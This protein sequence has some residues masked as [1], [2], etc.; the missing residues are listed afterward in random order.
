M[1]VGVIV[2]GVKLED[3]Y[4]HYSGVEAPRSCLPLLRV[5]GSTWDWRVRRR[6][7]SE[8]EEAGEDGGE[9][10]STIF[11]SVTEV[12]IEEGE[13]MAVLRSRSVSSLIRCS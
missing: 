6:E 5:A 9:A 1:S 7:G 13:S 3:T 10:E 8:S 11:T 2:S 4:E 12:L